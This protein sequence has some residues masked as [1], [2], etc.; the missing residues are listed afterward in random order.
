MMITHEER[1]ACLDEIL[2][3]TDFAFET[4]DAKGLV[5]QFELAIGAV[6]DKYR[7]SNA[8]FAPL[9]LSRNVLQAAI[10][11]TKTAYREH[12]KKVED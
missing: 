5:K 2:K 11:F 4:P 10:L 8:Q 7:N 9:T 12:L 1:M 3:E 6:G